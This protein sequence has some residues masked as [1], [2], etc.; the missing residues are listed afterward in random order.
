VVTSVYEE[1]DEEEVERVILR[2]S[3]RK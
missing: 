3:K 2:R 1:I